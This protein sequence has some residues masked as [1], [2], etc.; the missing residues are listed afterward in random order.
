VLVFSGT[1]F[2]QTPKISK[3]LAE[4]AEA[5]VKVRLCF[6]N[7]TCQAVDIRDREEGL[8]GTLSAKIRASLT[9]YHDLLNAPNCEIRLHSATLYA[10]LFRYDNEMMVN[11]H[12]WGQ[13]ASTNPVMHLRRLDGTGWFDHYLASFE[14]VWETAEAWQPGERN[15]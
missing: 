5:G 13:P 9:Y 6:G 2:A 12:A 4:R 8:R 11:P 15:S 14:A 7:P 3:M 10:S 1:F